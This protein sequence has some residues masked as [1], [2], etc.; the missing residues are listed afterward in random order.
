MAVM[1]VSLVLKAVMQNDGDFVEV[2]LLYTSTD[3]RDIKSRNKGFGRAF[4]IYRCAPISADSVSAGS[5]NRGRSW[6]VLPTIKG[7]H[8]Y[9][10]L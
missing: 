9:H 8:L 4:Y 6:N 5:R 1:C 10:K 7:A 2:I 3:I